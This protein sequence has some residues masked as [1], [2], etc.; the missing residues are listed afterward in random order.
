[1][2]NRPREQALLRSMAAVPAIVLLVVAATR[3]GVAQTTAIPPPA[4]QS[5]TAAPL[6]SSEM[7]D[8]MDLIRKIRHKDTSPDQERQVRGRGTMRAIAP[9][10]GY[11]PSSGGLI[12]VAGN[13]AFF[14]G[15]PETTHISSTV[16][17]FTFSSKKQTSIAGRSSIFGRDDRWSFDGDNRLQ[18]TSQDTFGLGATTTKDD[19][20]NTS[21]NYFRVYDAA[22]LRVRGNVFA[23]LGLHY[24]AHTSVEPGT[25]ADAAWNDSPYV[26]YSEA[27]G[28][29]LSD[30]TSGGFSLNLRGDARDS[31]INPSRGWLGSVSYRPFLKGFIGGDSSWQELYLDARTY[32]AFDRERRHKLA[33]WLWGDLV[34]HGVAPYMDLP[35]TGMDKYGRSARGYAEGRFRGERLLYG[36][37]E[38]RGTLTKNG[39]LGMVAFVN[40]TT[41]TNLEQDERLFDHFASGAGAGLRLLLNKQSMTNLCFDVGWGKQGSRGLYLAVQEA[42]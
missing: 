32:M 28:F 35:A 7:V 10:I 40:T 42:F 29:S 17:S 11:K 6:V 24:S 36:E 13:V 37:V 27:N 8:V 23:G 16:V 19:A 20:V 9:I 25:G 18:W 2:E 21:F 39:L 1:M 38:Y 33:F 31:A 14:R 34:T 5:A 41:L 12:G 15:D 3:A 22:Y 26:T 30:Q 4:Q